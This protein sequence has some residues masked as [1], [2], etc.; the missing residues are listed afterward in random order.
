MME[1]YR[2]TLRA[3]VL[4]LVT[5]G[6]VA[7]Q[8]Q[9]APAP[10]PVPEATDATWDGRTEPG[11]MSAIG[12][13]QPARRAK[14]SFGASGPVRV[15]AVQMGMAV[16]Q[17]DLLAEL[18]TARLE[19]AVAEAEDALAFSQALLTQAKAGAREQELAIARA[20]Y[21]MALAEHQQLMAGARPQEIARAEAEYEAALA[22]YDQVRSG[23]SPEAVIAAQASVEKAEVALTAAQAEYDRHAWQQ[24][25]EASPQ[26]AALHQATI[27]YQAAKAQYEGLRSLPSDAE[28][29]EGRADL[30]RAEAQLELVQAG[31]TAQEVAA[32]A[33]L[34]AASEARLGLGE[35]GARPEDVAV[36]E[37][38]V[39]QARTALERARL[40]LAEARLLAPFDGT[41]SAVYLSPGE[42]ATPGMPA[43][44]L[45]DTRSWRVETRNLGELIIGRVRVGQEAAVRVLAFRSEELRGHVAAISPVAVVQQG[46]TT[47]TVIVELP[48]TDL[49]LRPGMNAEV[50]LIGE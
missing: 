12:T 35:A 9:E 32:S 45:L 25:F 43:V 13:I 49:S 38:R 21:Q 37:A 18:D 46:D 31:P 5:L 14:L 17:G 34:V 41:V 50:D 22:R 10:M 15:V 3:V 47:Y 30:A 1:S 42:R 8:G 44:E 11:R 4:V 19:L 7:C 6:L 33:N 20:E 28:V 16:R 40:G 39:Q 24:G 29:R 2:S 23:A 48:P 26:A 36:A 27:E